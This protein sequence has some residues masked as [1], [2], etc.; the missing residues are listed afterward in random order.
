MSNRDHESAVRI[1]AGL[2][3][4]LARI[5]ATTLERLRAARGAALDRLRPQPAEELALAGVGTHPVA[6]R[7]Y[8]AVRYALPAAGLLLVML[9]VMYLQPSLRVDDVAEIDAR[10][11]S[12]DLPID[13]YLDKALDAWLKR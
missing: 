4:G 9:G 2:N 10:L 11:L 6:S 5:D 7:R 8:L 12:G 3:E 13:A 1:V